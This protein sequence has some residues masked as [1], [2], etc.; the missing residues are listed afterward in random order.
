MEISSPNSSSREKDK[1]RYSR[2][3][4]YADK[5]H[6]MD[7][8][9][10]IHSPS[11]RENGTQKSNFIWLRLV[12]YGYFSVTIYRPR[13]ELALKRRSEQKQTASKSARKRIAMIRQLS[14]TAIA[15]CFC[16]TTCLS[17]SGQNTG[18]TGYPPNPS[19]YSQPG[20][21][22]PRPSQPGYYAQPSASSATVQGSPAYATSVPPGSNSQP[23]YS[24][25]NPAQPTQPPAP[26]SLQTPPQG[27]VPVAGQ[28]NPPRYANPVSS[29]MMPVR[30]TAPVS[31][32]PTPS[33]PINNT[34]TNWTP[35]SSGMSNPSPS[36]RTPS[37]PQ[38]RADWLA[39]QVVEQPQPY[40]RDRVDVARMFPEDGTF[41]RV[42]FE[43]TEEQGPA[44]GANPEDVEEAIGEKPPEEIS[45][46]SLSGSSI[47]LKQGVLQSEIGFRYSRNQ[48]RA[49]NLI[50]ETVFM[51]RTARRSLVVP[52]SIR[53]GATE[54]LELY[55]SVPFGLA[56]YEQD[57]TYFESSDIVGVMGDV[58][59]GF[60]TQ[61]VS[62][63]EKLPN[64]TAACNFTL[65][66]G[67]P[68]FRSDDPNVAS[69]G[70]GFW[71]V[72]AS[73]NF[74]E[75]YDPIVFFG[76]F[77]Y[78]YSF[79][80]SFPRYDIRP[81]GTLTYNFGVG[82]GLSDDVSMSARMNGA[83]SDRLA[84]DGRSIPD[85]DSEPISLRL[86]VIRRITKQ[87][88]IQFFTAFGLTDDASEATFGISLIHDEL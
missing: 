8:A 2:W 72:G 4:D 34:S 60:I 78:G 81:G 3:S 62:G 54:K 82:L 86:S 38:V 36:T 41:D 46:R 45:H 59:T 74:V 84:V 50:D 9:E 27:F 14:V 39:P 19:G 67:S 73:L 63:H 37:A 48:T 24:Q 32:Y 17:T 12:Y 20:Y 55:G 21:T 52:L 76:G 57:N 6:S 13:G 53:Y 70:S 83:W 28:T 68:S 66:T 87:D 64:M 26:A 49:V 15:L 5:Q 23:G 44:P 33:Q 29:N 25:P 47:L 71:G 77:G 75:S 40:A 56:F 80:H 42:A 31:G 7:S 1:N 11:M 10:Y 85:S 43:T 61:V 22:L 51:T 65:P 88:R 69:L 58:N 16:A 79:E 30:S 35:P 18:Y